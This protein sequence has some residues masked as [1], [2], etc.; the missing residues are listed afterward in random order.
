MTLSTAT[1]RS[2]FRRNQGRT[3]IFFNP[4][5]ATLAPPSSVSLLEAALDP[6]GRLHAV[7]R[8]HLLRGIAL[9]VDQG[10]LSVRQP[11]RAVGGL[12]DGLVP[13]ADRHAH[14]AA[15]TFE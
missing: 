14:R 12:H 11:G 8:V 4:Q 5:L 7:R 2:W 15:R 9:D 13:L 1:E 3:T 10:E 6:V